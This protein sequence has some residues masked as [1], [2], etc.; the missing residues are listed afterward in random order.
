MAMGLVAAVMAVALATGQ[1]A[2]APGTPTADQLKGATYTGIN[3]TPVTLKDGAWEGPPVGRSKPRVVLQFASLEVGAITADGAPEAVVL[4]RKSSGG[5]GVFTFIAVVADRGGKIENV[6]T[7]PLGDHEQ[8]RSLS[9]VDRRIVAEV[10]GY[11]PGEPMCCPTQRQRRTWYWTST[12]LKELPREVR[13]LSTVADLESRAWTLRSLDNDQPLPKGVT[14]T[15]SVKNR[16]VDG[17]GGCNTY[18]GAIADGNGSRA[19]EIGRLGSTRRFCAGA[20]GDVEAKYLAALQAVFQF[21][22]VA[23]DL[24][25]TYKDGSVVRTLMFSGR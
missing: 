19:L 15:L 13:G 1:A 16:R 11:G 24:A 22:F 6:A 7:A 9:I 4:L 20:P 3:D 23:G 5:T 14:V 18:G 2:P 12:G 25:L 21:G 8:V 10:I 17:T